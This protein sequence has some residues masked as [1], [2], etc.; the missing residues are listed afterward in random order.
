MNKK[1]FFLSLVPLVVFSI[2]ISGQYVF[3]KAEGPTS[4]YWFPDE[5][6]EWSPEKDSDARFNRSHVPLQ[7]ERV[8]DHVNKAIQS[9]SRLVALSALNQHTSGV[10][11]QGGTTF[12]ENTFSYWQYTDLMVYWAGSAGEG[13]IVPPSADVIDMA[14]TNGVPILGNVFFPPVV[15]GGQ[16]EW[17]E[18][19]L[20]EDG[21]GRFPMADKLLEVADYYGFDGWFINQ[22][23]EGAT[24]E[25]AKKMREFLV[26]LQENK[27]S[28]L[29][30]MWYDSMIE[31]GRIA[32]QNHLTP[33]N[34]MYL[35]EEGNRVSDSMF[36]N[37]W[38][39]DQSRS[40]SLADVLGRSPYD[41]Y[42][43]V[44]VE[45]SGTNTSVPWSGLF[46]DDG[47][48]HTSLG[49]YRPDWAFKTSDTM[50]SFYQKEQD[51][52]VGS[53]GDPSLTNRGDSWPGM[54]HFYQAKSPVTDLPFITH[55]NTGSGQGYSI[56]GDVRSD[57]EWNNRS[58]QDVLPTWRW[59]TAGD[60]D[61][62]V[63]FD[64]EES[65]EG[66]SSLHVTSE[67]G[68][69][70]L[71]TIYLYESDLII[72]EDVVSSITYKSP[73]K[74]QVRLGIRLD[75]EESYQFMEQQD[76]V[77]EGDWTVSSYKLND[78]AGKKVRGLAL[79]VES[80][81][82]QGIDLHI[83]GLT[84]MNSVE[85]KPKTPKVELK[86]YEGS[87]EQLYL[88]WEKDEMV[89]Q[90]NVYQ[91]MENGKRIFLKAS[92]GDVLYLEDLYKVANSTNNHTVKLVVE[93]VSH[94]FQTSAST[95]VYVQR[96]SF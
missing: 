70:D 82:S 51:F 6:K 88:Q 13:I 28:N 81:S 32:W 95:E 3:A 2:F 68:N 94:T 23:T 74:E 90:T 76:V 36:L 54:A 80:T 92:V 96:R 42:A 89:K 12:F 21:N 33:L 93:A 53:K 49:L 35:Q 4:S 47:S 78:Y 64:W 25:M 56:R 8:K 77:M 45:A 86:R 55:F 19:M 11:S 18:E 15:Y 20:Y 83:G 50:E 71:G 40:A 63:A 72:E 67:Q 59:K 44:D 52:W 41:L 43:G 48:A 65:F 38:W 14:H 31:D 66:G 29:E 9:D 75:G 73:N 39:R 91:E 34:Q 30:I 10:P 26:Y 87:T 58:L 69:G 37:F 1:M 24:S 57:R 84:V 62:Q 46:P 85:N 7:K 17:L 16:I 60:A 27:P 5:L 61:L 22:E 79:E